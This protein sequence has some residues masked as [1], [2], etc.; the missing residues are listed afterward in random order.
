MKWPWTK[1]SNAIVKANNQTGAPDANTMLAGVFDGTS[2]G[3]D[4]LSMP[5]NLGYSNQYNPLSLNRILLNYAY[6][7]HGPLQTMIDQPVED[8]FRKGI[9]IKSEELDDEDIKLLQKVMEQCHDITAVKDVMRWAKLFGGAALIINTD[10]DPTQELTLDDIDEKSPLVFIAADRWEIML[11]FLISD[12]VA[13]PYNYYGQPIHKSRVIKVNGK[14]APSFIRKRL[15]GWGFSEVERV[16][17]PYTQYVKEEDLIYQ[18]LDEAKID[19]YKITGLNANLLST[20]GQNKLRNRFQFANWLKNFH[21]ALMMDKEDEY[22]QKQI[23]FAGLAEM[24]KQIQIGVAAAIRM[25]MSK[26]FG[27]QAQGFSSG[28][29]DIENYN[30]LIESEVRAKAKEVL[31]QVVPLRC[32]QIFGFVPEDLEYEFYPLRV[33]TAEQQENVNNI[34]FNRHS[35]LFSQ[36]IYTGKEY[37]EALKQDDLMNIETEVEKGLRAPEVPEASMQTDVPQKVVKERRPS[38]S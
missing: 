16:I 2:Y 21:S 24:M 37:V 12:E 35:A 13:C 10:S 11:Q 8:A 19:V 1:I 30:A 17:R 32:K 31:A 7:T 25:P 34:K 6:M 18:L 14:E 38:T 22:E 4:P 33:L 26:I 28:E 9:K 15:Q 23:T 5:Y 29:D 27:L 36:G 20:P 3:S